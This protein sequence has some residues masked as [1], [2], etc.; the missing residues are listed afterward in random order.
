MLTKTSR[1]QTLEEFSKVCAFVPLRNST[2]N[3]SDRIFLSTPL[4]K[5]KGRRGTVISKFEPFVI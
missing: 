3:Y 1:I 2:E 5:H 4:V